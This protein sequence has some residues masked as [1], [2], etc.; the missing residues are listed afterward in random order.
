MQLYAM[1]FAIAIFEAGGCCGGIF[2]TFRLL[3]DRNARQSANGSATLA[4]TT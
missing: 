3:L 1:I 2:K 4:F